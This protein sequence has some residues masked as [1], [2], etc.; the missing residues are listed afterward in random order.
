MATFDPDNTSRKK[1]TNYLSKNP[2]YPDDRVVALLMRFLSHRKSKT[3]KLRGIDIGC[4]VGRHTKLLDDLGFEA[5]GLDYADN[6][7]SIVL[8]YFPNLNPDRLI[9]ADYRSINLSVKFSV[10]IAWGTVFCC[11]KSEI[12]VNL[13]KIFNLLEDEGEL[14]VNFRTPENWFYGMG[15]CI[16]DDSFLLSEEAEN[17]SGL[18]YSFLSDA[19]AERIIQSAGFSVLEKQKLELTECLSDNER[20]HSWLIYR[21]RKD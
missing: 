4:G 13:R 20:K 16:E 17:Y 9:Q 2:K 6:L 10:A 14:I 3:G 12:I 11:K 5:W 1:F 7:S 21:L 19:E 15:H 8:Q 18:L